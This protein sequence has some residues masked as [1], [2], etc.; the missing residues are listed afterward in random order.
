MVH[1]SQDG[2]MVLWWSVVR[3]VSSFKRN[4]VWKNEFLFCLVLTCHVKIIVTLKSDKA[5]ISFCFALIY[6][7]IISKHFML[8]ADYCARQYPRIMK[9]GS[10]FH[11]TR[12][13]MR[14]KVCVAL[15]RA[16]EV[17]G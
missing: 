13:V 4:S 2:Q 9:Y 11:R 8:R 7:F 10:Y 16:E 15:H 14:T 3:N 1:F 5:N 17:T 12:G 6:L